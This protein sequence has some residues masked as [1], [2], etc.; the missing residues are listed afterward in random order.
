MKKWNGPFTEFGLG[1]GVGYSFTKRMGINFSYSLGKFYNED[2]SRL[3]IGM[4]F[5]L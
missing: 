3:Y 1:L 5:K 2:K 4:G